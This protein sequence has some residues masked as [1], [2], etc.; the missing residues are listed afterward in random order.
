MRALC[1]V[2]GIAISLAVGIIPWFITPITY[3]TVLISIA[4]AAM[5]VLCIIGLIKGWACAFGNKESS[6]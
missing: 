6:G 3:I 5:L 1:Y 2:I 4:G